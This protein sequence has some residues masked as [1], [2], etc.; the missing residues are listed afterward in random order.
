VDQNGVVNLAD[1]ILALQVAGGLVPPSAYAAGDA[2]SD[3]TIGLEEVIYILQVVS[4][5]RP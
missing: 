4:G 2:N 5:L 1:A 3:Q